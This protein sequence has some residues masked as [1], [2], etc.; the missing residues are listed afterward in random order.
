MVSG[1]GS[2][3]RSRSPTS[4]PFSPLVLPRS[5]ASPAHP[6]Q[7]SILTPPVCPQDDMHRVIDRQLM[8]SHLKERSRPPAT[9]ARAP[10]LG[11]L[12]SRCNFPAVHLNDICNSY[13]N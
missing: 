13:C 5:A 11:R 12:S 8:D 7:V 6:R 2:R 3:G 1:Q 4:L 10:G 9:L